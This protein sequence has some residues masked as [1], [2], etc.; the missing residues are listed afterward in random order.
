M[1]HI[2]R[3]HVR[4]C[5]TA[6]IFGV[7]WFSASCLPSVGVPPGA[8]ISC[9]SDSDCLSG[10][11]C[12]EAQLCEEINQT[13]LSANEPS[14]CVTSENAPGLC[15]GRQCVQSVCGDGFTDIRLREGCDDGDSNFDGQRATCHADCQLP[16]CGDGRLGGNEMCELQTEFPSGLCLSSCIPKCDWRFGD[17]D[18]DASNGCECAAEVLSD[19]DLNFG[20]QEIIA[21][22]GYV[23]IFTNDGVVRLSQENGER[24]LV[25]PI[26]GAIG[27]KTA[28][29]GEEHL[30]VAYLDDD[31]V[32]RLARF[33]LDG[34]ETFRI[35]PPQIIQGIAGGGDSVYA[36]TSSQLFVVNAN[37]QSTTLETGLETVGIDN[38]IAVF[39]ES[40]YWSAPEEGVIRKRDLG[41]ATA[42]FTTVVADV[43]GPQRIANINDMF[44]VYYGDGTLRSYDNDFGPLETVDLPIRNS[45]ARGGAMVAGDDLLIL[46][47][48][49][50][51]DGSFLG[52]AVVPSDN[53]ARFRV[54]ASRDSQSFGFAITD[55]DVWL[56]SYDERQRIPFFGP[57]TSQNDGGVLDGGGLQDGGDDDGGGPTDAGADSGNPTND[58]GL[59][60]GLSND[61]AGGQ[62]LDAG[63]LEDAG[64]SNAAASA[65]IQDVRDGVLPTEIM[66]A[67]VVDRRDITSAGADVPGFFIQADAQGP[68]LFVASPPDSVG[69]V[70]GD[71]I[72]LTV[73]ETVLSQGRVEATGIESVQVLSR[74]NVVTSL[75]QDVS[76]SADLIS[77][78]NNYEA[79]L[80]TA[81]LSITS[82]RFG[83]GPSF[84]AQGVA[85]QGLPQGDLRIRFPET[86]ALELDLGCTF[87]LRPHSLWRFNSV[88]Q[89]SVFD[90]EDIL[91]LECP[92]TEVTSI[93]ATS[94]TTVVVTTS[95]ALDENTIPENGTSFTFNGG[96]D[97]ISSSVSGAS[98]F[99][100]TTEQTPEQG[101]EL[102]IAPTVRD[103]NGDP[104]LLPNG[105]FTGFKPFG[106]S[107]VVNE[108]LYDSIQPGD[109]LEFIEFVNTGTQPIDFSTTPIRIV[110]VNGSTGQGYASLSVDTGV[111]GVNGRMVAGKPDSV[112]QAAAAEIVIDFQSFNLQNGSPDGFAILDGAN[113][114]VAAYVW[115]GEI[116]T[117][118]FEGQNFNVT[119][120]TTTIAEHQGS[121]GS[122]CVLPDLTGA[123]V[124][125]A[126]ATPGAVN[127]AP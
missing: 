64:L 75:V 3:T 125:C 49:A 30:C 81:T 24:S 122:S 9:S 44:F 65:A 19:A 31:F 46:T 7:L 59:D 66:G 13:C 28:V 124:E 40:L 41:S 34:E 67:Y 21:R 111:L 71:E 39:G 37:G 90:S 12:G 35:S 93:S 22:G 103:V 112:A 91:D 43:A 27:L 29:C 114:P 70:V 33:N 92:P 121:S 104:I 17:C 42:G 117:F 109:S 38:A 36:I 72:S 79:E 23:F 96:L 107:I 82:G 119:G 57:K 60:A 84:A 127:T 45:N 83:A 32:P 78:L 61:D 106:A 98:V 15:D 5:R 55:K 108:V 47:G 54:I 116:Q 25:Y 53:L 4:I 100:T 102:S 120:L 69:V 86:F 74:G 58:A 11:F 1:R 26:V 73:T 20:N 52:I 115:E 110:A 77:N 126:T 2:F 118:T 62:P 101:Y 14:T 89:F 95:R 85:S 113:N 18:G 87:R 76:D 48:T 105:S 80:V 50:I 97:A 94:S 6:A 123:W 10:F 56:T 99:I 8:Q 88:V 63:D 68:G 16:V 51:D